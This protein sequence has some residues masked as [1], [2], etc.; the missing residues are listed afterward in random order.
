MRIIKEAS[1]EAIQFHSEC[2]TVDVHCHPSIKVKLFNFNIY[3]RIHKVIG[4]AK[5]DDNEEIFQM[6]YD[7]WQMSNGGIDSIW[8]SIYV[9]EREFAENSS[10]K[11]G[12]FLSKVLGLG[13]DESIE[14]DTN[15]GPFNQAIDIMDRMEA[16][17]KKAQKAGWEATYAFSY[18][19]FE[20]ALSEGK[21]C[22]V[23]TLEGAHMLGR[24]YDK[25]QTY[26]DRLKSFAQR[27]V[28]SMTLAHFIPNNICFPASGISPKTRAG[29]AFLFD[30]DPYEKRGLTS[31]G[32]EVVNSMLDLGI[33]VDLNHVTPRGREDVY[34]LNED[35]ES[36]GLKKRPLV[37][38]HTGI[39][40]NC[41]KELLTPTKEE[42]I[43]IQKCNGI[44][45][46][47]FMNYWLVGT[48]GIPDDGIENIVKTINDIAAI[49]GSSYDNIAIGTDM[50]GFTQPVDDLYSPVQM[51]R[52]TQ[53][54]IDS[55]IKP[56]D[57]K[58]V[59]GEN[60][61]RVMKDGWGK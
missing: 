46:V 15:E 58:K 47:I 43:R 57:I 22:F 26:L 36:R 34:K 7:L 42:I 16:Q 53:A 20:Q 32:H 11:Y 41:T 54:M 19:E 45:G 25:L 14:R 44:I 10:M 40:D 50:D 35:R 48:E 30:Y 5:P 13:L 55:K 51:P 27:G 37:F 9:V 8:S 1:K 17:M 4:Q 60:A 12:V 49:C 23:H 61:I 6:Q 24:H 59:L 33:I 2:R 3:D 56:E 31:V 28:C 29:L 39:R 18:N 52:L 38:T 21:K